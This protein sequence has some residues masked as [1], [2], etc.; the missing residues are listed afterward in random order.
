V[1]PLRFWP[2][3]PALLLLQ[4][5]G[6]RHFSWYQFL[7]FSLFFS[8][9]S[10]P[11]FVFSIESGIR[12]SGR[13]R[14]YFISQVLNSAVWVWNGSFMQIRSNSFFGRFEFSNNILVSGFNKLGITRIKDLLPFC[15]GHFKQ[16]ADDIRL[17][18]KIKNI[19]YPLSFSL[20]IRFLFQMH[21]V[22][23]FLKQIRDLM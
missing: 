13:Q 20:I 4:Q 1:F 9:A 2:L 11:H 14:H 8:L 17:N 5:L 7:R 10:I 19:H 3:W 15:I 22:S 16:K 23:D 6:F 18:R 21:F 12:G